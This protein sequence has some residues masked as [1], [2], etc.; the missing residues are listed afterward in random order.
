VRLALAAMRQIVRP[1]FAAHDVFRIPT[2]QAL[3][4]VRELGFANLAITA[5]ALLSVK[6]PEFVRPG[7]SKAR[8]FT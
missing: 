3:P 1:E 6:V 8:S 4:V 5:V 7:T 2:D